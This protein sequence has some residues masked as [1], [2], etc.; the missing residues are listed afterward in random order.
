MSVIIHSVHWQINFVR[1]FLANVNSRTR[2]LYVVVR[3]SVCLSIVC[4]SVVC[5]VRA[6]YS[7]DWNFWQCFYAIWYPDHLWPFGKNFT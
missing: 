2:S 4:L 1:S 7:G 6:P 5:N 3:P